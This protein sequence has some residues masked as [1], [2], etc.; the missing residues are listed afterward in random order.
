MWFLGQC[1]TVVKLEQQLAPIICH[2]PYSKTSYSS[3]ALRVHGRWYWTTGP[4]TS[5]MARFLASF[6]SVWKC[7]G[8][9]QKKPNR[10]IHEKC[11][12][13]CIPYKSSHTPTP[14]LSALFLFTFFSS[15][16]IEYVNHSY[17]H[18]LHWVLCMQLT[19]F[20]LILWV[21]KM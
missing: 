17:L 9:R 8:T 12:E 6:V 1:F 19:I 2:N 7:E 18:M 10:G 5:C 20:R 21:R 14:V 3:R 4:C 15:Y 16:P 13:I 11:K